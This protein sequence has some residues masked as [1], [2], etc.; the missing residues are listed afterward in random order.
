MTLGA[1]VLHCASIPVGV[2]YYHVPRVRG[3]NITGKP[4][5][6]L[7]RSLEWLIAWFLV[8]VVSKQLPL[9]YGDRHIMSLQCIQCPLIVS[10]I[11]QAMYEFVSLFSGTLI[12]TWPPTYLCLKQP[13]KTK[14]SCKK[15]ASLA[16][17]FLARSCIISYRY[18]ASN[19]SCKK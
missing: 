4:P 11:Y 2:S 17:I 14:P 10:V 16:S 8:M 7:I 19:F 1:I 13:S 3:Y 6:F 15:Y 9:P 5:I 12:I 18:L